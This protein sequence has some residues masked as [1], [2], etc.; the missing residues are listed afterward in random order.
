MKTVCFYVQGK[1]VDVKSDNLGEFEWNELQQG[2]ILSSFFWGYI[3]F[4]IPGG[5]IAELWGPKVVFGTSV[6]LNGLLSLILPFIA[7]MHWILLLI[8]RAL[9]GLGQGV[10]FPCL[11]ASVPRWVPVEE[12]ARF[13]SFAIQGLLF[14]S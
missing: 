6:L 7:R 10:I 13:I 3:F 2:V 5:R 14:C 11:T 9:Q 12:R 4:Q 1:L 8:V